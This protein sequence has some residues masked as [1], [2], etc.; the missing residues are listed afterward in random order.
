M[1]AKRRRELNELSE[2]EALHE[3]ER[4]LCKIADACI[5][6]INLRRPL[7]PLNLSDDIEKV[8]ETSTRMN[9]S[10]KASHTRYETPQ[11]TH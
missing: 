8:M 7:Q 2:H 11:H 9:E 3:A 10:L 4:Q 5:V 1:K 6:L